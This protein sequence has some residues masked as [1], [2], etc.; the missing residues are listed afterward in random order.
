MV[1]VSYQGKVNVLQDHDL[2]SAGPFDRA[3]WFALL[4]EKPGISP[5]VA[6]ARDG[7]DAAALVLKE[8]EGRLEPLTNWYAFAWRPLFTRHA[9]R[10]KLL[11]DLAKGL[12]RRAR[13]VTLWP[14]PE[15]DGS[16]ELLESAFRAAGWTCFRASCDVAHVLPVGG[17]DYAGYLAA[18]PGPLRTTL[19]RKAKKIDIEIDTE[20]QSGIWDIYENIYNTS[21]K[22]TEGDP[23]ILKAF[24]RAEGAAGRLRLGIARHEGKPVAAQFWT[25]E[26]GTAFIHK[27]AHLPE[28]QPLS[29]GSVL[30]AALMERV[31]D[32]DHVHTVDFGT[33]DDSYKRDWMEAVYPRYLLDCHNPASP[34][35]WPYILRGMA[36]RLASRGRSG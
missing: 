12:K 18:R 8:G 5:H 35:A 9:D 26:G 11:T 2:A 17:R 31:I 33:G 32:G 1:E 24:A 22:P 7:S 3:E 15:E 19:K 13:R 10:L 27:L 6:L 25:V 34:R 14:L 29:A 21:W 23:A 4:A 36:R 28:A 30:T 20:F 16:A